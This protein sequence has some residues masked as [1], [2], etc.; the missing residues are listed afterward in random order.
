MKK[1]AT[2]MLKLITAMTNK[3]LKELNVIDYWAGSEVNERINAYDLIKMLIIEGK[4]F[5]TAENDI[6]LV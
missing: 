2:D 4:I 5:R 1:E 3:P 6:K